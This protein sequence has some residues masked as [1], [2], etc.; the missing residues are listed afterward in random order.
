M[1]YTVDD[2]LNKLDNCIE[3]KLP[4]SHIRFGDGGIK[5]IDSLL[6]DNRKLLATIVKKE[7]LPHE[8]LMDTFLLKNGLCF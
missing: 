1:I 5:L 2:I 7:G 3:Y 8:Y 6:Y 4:F